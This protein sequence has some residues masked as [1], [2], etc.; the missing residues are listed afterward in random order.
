MSKLGTWAAENPSIEEHYAKLLGNEQAVCACNALQQIGVLQC[1]AGIHTCGNRAGRRQRPGEDKDRPLRHAPKDGA[2]GH[3]ANAACRGVV[4]CS[5]RVRWRRS[6]AG[7]AT[8][9][10]PRDGTPGRAQLTPFRDHF[11]VVIR[12]AVSCCN[13]VHPKT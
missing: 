11:A 7:S 2:E 8:A 12:V 9:G 5:R 6:R 1:I 10:R 4:S 13:T 3:L